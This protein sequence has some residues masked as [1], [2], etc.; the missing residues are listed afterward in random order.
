MT[1]EG[2]WLGLKWLWGK[3]KIL[4][5]GKNCSV[6]S[7]NNN[8]NSCFFNSGTLTVNFM[9]SDDECRKIQLSAEE[10]EILFALAEGA[11]I[12]AARD[13]SGNWADAVAFGNEKATLIPHETVAANLGAMFRKG[14]IDKADE[15]HFRISETGRRIVIKFDLG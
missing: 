14:L 11:E 10:R 15:S 8:N 13:E 3:L 4:L 12:A 6:N 7:A 2:I 5:S 9:A 1:W